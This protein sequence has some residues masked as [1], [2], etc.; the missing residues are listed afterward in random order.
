METKTHRVYYILGDYISATLAWISF[1]IFRKI[2]IEEAITKGSSIFM[3]FELKFW[4]ALFGIPL[5]WV[6]FYR[7]LGHYI[8]VYRR[9]RI[10]E[11]WQ[12][13][14]A[15]L[16]GMVIMFFFILLDDAVSSYKDYYYSFIFLFGTH[17]ILTLTL[18][19]LHT[20]QIKRK[21]AKGLISF[22][23][24]IVGNRKDALRL[25]N[26]IQIGQRKYGYNI[27]GY[28]SIDAENKSHQ[29][30]DLQCV[31]CYDNL[32]K[33]IENSS[34]REVIIA[35]EAQNDSKIK[36][37]M[38]RLLNRS[39]YVNIIPEMYGI[40]SGRMKLDSILHLP[41]LQISP[42]NMPEWQQNFK[43]LL[44]V[45]ISIFAMTVFSPLYLF[46][47][48][49]VRS[50]GKGKIF[51]SHK[52]VGRYGKS[53]TIYK[54]RSMRPDAEKSGPA[55][56]SKG[57]P[58]I[59]RFGSFMRK[60]RLDEI[61]QFYNVL[62]GDMSLVGPRPER[63]FYIDQI[64]KKAPNYLTLQRIRPGITSLGQVKFGYAENVDEMI[65]RMR[66]DIL[67]LQNM[68]LYLDFKILL[69]TILVVLGR[70]GV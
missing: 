53:F 63:Q 40:Y 24:V 4:V 17:F 31:G 38:I 25:F 20:I 3:T 1:Y 5:I 44:D 39:V 51:Y 56:S 61:P 47:A 8:Y 36:D 52:R 70:K 43:R 28:I 41:V 16:I 66:Y 42:D 33:I 34:V 19:A 46:L 10:I 18:R 69:Q 32:E 21:I 55:L 62:I 68:S 67:Y 35:P 60:Y 6:L 29:G 12:T 9:T 7:L 37:I 22:P 13:L 49:G 30:D 64:I 59:T 2:Y 15:S 54:F 27:I 57:D 65:Q 48:I 23:T 50:S 11:F 26:E 14:T 45:G 58:R